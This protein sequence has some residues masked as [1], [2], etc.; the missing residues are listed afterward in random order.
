MQRWPVTLASPPM[1]T[2]AN[3]HYSKS[4]RPV[5]AHIREHLPAVEDQRLVIVDKMELG[6]AQS[7]KPVDLSLEKVYGELGE[8]AELDGLPRQQLHRK[9][10][11]VVKRHPNWMVVRGCAA[12]ECELRR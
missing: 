3:D 10:K 11:A 8:H 12:Q 1:P 6:A 4:G 9:V 7:K 5:N 2:G